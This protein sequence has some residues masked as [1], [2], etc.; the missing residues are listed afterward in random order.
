MQANIG[1]SE[2]ISYPF[3][4]G[5]MGKPPEIIAW[6]RKNRPV[7]PIRLPSGCHAWMLTRKDDIHM[8]LTDRRFS[9]DLTYPGG[10]RF[11][12]EDFNALPGG[13]FNLDPPDHTRVKQV[14]Y[15]FYTRE[16][17]ARLE[18]P[19]TL[20]A[21]KFL[22]AIG[23]GPNPTDLIPHY[24]APLPLEVSSFILRVPA[25]LRSDYAKF[26]KAQ[27]NFVATPE[28]VATG[29]AAIVAF[30]RDVIR[31]RSEH[32]DREDPIAALIDAHRSGS[33]SEDELVSTVAYLFITGSDPL[34]SPL[35]TGVFTL[36]AHPQELRR[37]LQDPLLW[38][39]AVEE[40]LRYHHNGV[41]GMPRVALE[42]LV[43]HDVTIRKGDAVCATMLGA[44]WD[45][46][47]YDSPEK[48][49]ILRKTDGT[50]TF[51]AGPHF[52]L[53]ATLTRQFLLIAYRKLFERFPSLAM[54]VSPEQVPWEQDIIFTKPACL[55]VV[56]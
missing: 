19:I 23:S 47:Y 35:G 46:K 51:G 20:I 6:A 29:I 28:E 38:P 2:R 24:A 40:V 26:F 33:I 54:A 4:P 13:L 12:G 55:P 30:C 3:T 16:A 39:K 27:T 5:S 21:E 34:V 49:R 17:V 22:D 25:E 7:C 37:C 56:W 10:P 32:G 44:T 50:A 48:F 11:V 18:D 31:S 14:I 42:D 41:L 1:E 15:R 52:C 9:R 43:L 53:G 36:L 45:P 8:L